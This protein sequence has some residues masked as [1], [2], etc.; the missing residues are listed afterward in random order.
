MY[1]KGVGAVSQRTQI[2]EYLKVR[3]IT[4]LIALDRFGCFRLAAIIERLRGKGYVIETE[5][6]GKTKHAKYTL[7]AQPKK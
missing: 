5:L 4:P 2:L 6:V 1:R 7:I 3:P